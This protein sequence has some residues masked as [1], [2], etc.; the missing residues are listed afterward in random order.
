MNVLVFLT[1]YNEEKTI[2]DVLDGLEE[3]ATTVD[4]PLDVL[5]VDD[6]SADDTG[7]VAEER[8]VTTIRHPRNLGPGAATQTAYKYAVCEGYDVT[9]R[10][11]A[12]GQH[13][14][15]DVPKLLEPIEAD[16][17]D[18]VIGSRYVTEAGYETPLVRDAGI[19][20]YSR[21]VSAVTGE[22]VHDITSGFRAVRIEMG[23]RHAENLPSGIIAIDR[24]LREGLSSY[25]VTEVPVTMRQRE[26]GSSYLNANRLFR[27]PLY[28]TYS[29]IS[30]LLHWNE[31]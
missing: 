18:V 19:R 25:R 11:D 13:R 21:L 3:V 14:P 17:A 8:G 6:G 22:R 29:F 4:H 9:V 12:D 30:T 20:F 16:E 28:S 23:R 15:A 5:V 31:R 7:R 1:A 27:Y 26:H 10:M 24:G 2:G